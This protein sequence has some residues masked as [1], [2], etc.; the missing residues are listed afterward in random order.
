MYNL[1]GQLISIKKIHSTVY[2]YLSFSYLPDGSFIG[3]IHG[4]LT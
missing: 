2:P 4:G 1:R 3:V